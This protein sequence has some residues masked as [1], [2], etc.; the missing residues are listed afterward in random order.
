MDVFGRTKSPW[1][2][3]RCVFLALSLTFG[4]LAMPLHVSAH[5]VPYTRVIHMILHDD[6]LE[7]YINFLLPPGPKVRLWMALFDR[8]RDG[9]LG[10]GE[11]LALGRFI[12]PKIVHGFTLLANQKTCSVM[13]R[14][15]QNSRL[16][17]DP[18]QKKYAWDLRYR[19][20]PL[21]LQEG[22]NRLEI[23][24]PFLTPS[25]EIPVALYVEK[26]FHVRRITKGPRRQPKRR[27]AKKAKRL[28]SQRAI[29]RLF[30]QR[31]SCAFWIEK[32]ASS[33]RVS[34]PSTHPSQTPKEAGQ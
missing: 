19:S 23:R 7:V 18:Q 31:A 8:N 12:A 30:Q 28:G 4:W 24:L 13:L 26:N 15:V 11:Q 5:Q 10:A 14:E 25:E 2:R 17:G 29:C 33:P 27:V 1:S 32:R 22:L 34:S 16:R 9:R 21:S 3:L 20:H 6:V